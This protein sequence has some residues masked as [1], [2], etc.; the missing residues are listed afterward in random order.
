MIKHTNRLFAT[1]ALLAS[2]AAC[3]SDAGASTDAGPI[4]GHWAQET[5][6]DNKGMTLEFDADSDKLM[7]HTAPAED[8]TH[9]HLDGTYSIDAKTGAVHYEGQRLSGLRTVYASPL[10]ADG[11]VYLVS[12]EGVT[13]VIKAGSTYEELATNELDD[14]FDASPIV[15]GDR[16]YLRG[17]DN[18]YC[19]GSK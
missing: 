4:A 14:A 5:G 9:D 3:G 10:A 12:R 17:H 8:G 7:V 16:L 1:L 19:L 6:S 11:R 18:L 13:K 2:L 15:I